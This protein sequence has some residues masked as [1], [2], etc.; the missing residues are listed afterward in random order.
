MCRPCDHGQI[1]C[2]KVC[3][4]LQRH[5]SVQRA[6]QTY[7]RSTVGKRMHAKAEARRRR[8]RK[9]KIVM[10]HGLAT[11]EPE[12]ILGGRAVEA[13]VVLVVTARFISVISS[14]FEGGV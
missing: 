13:S 10:D 14:R 2:G 5:E 9:A 8:E 3:A 6:R 1:Y 4:G 12:P 7:A 11:T